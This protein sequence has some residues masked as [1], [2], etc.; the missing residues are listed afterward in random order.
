[1]TEETDLER[2]YNTRE[3]WDMHILPW[4]HKRT[5]DEKLRDG[6]IPSVKIDGRWYIR[7]GDLKKFVEQHYSP[8]ILREETEYDP[9]KLFKELENPYDED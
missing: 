7:L 5:L 6:L 9:D 1:M 4:K 2:L 3:I 8:G